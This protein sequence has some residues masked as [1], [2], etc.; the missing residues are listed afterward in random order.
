MFSLDDDP[1]AG[2][3]PTPSVPPD[4]APP[5]PPH[6]PD[7]EPSPD[8][9]APLHLTHPEDLLADLNPPQRRAVVQRGGPLLVVAGAGSGKT[10]VLTRR[11]AHLLANGDAAPWE[12]LAITFTNKAADEMR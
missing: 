4:P 9:V 5:A 6:Q 2:F 8:L 10:R 3:D 1:P 12:I 11:I 7:D